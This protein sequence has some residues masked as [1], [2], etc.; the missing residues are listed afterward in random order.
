M[1]LYDIVLTNRYLQ[2]GSK[3]QVPC[4]YVTSLDTLADE[5]KCKTDTYI[6][7]FRLAFIVSIQSF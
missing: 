6:D 1:M 2:T 4:V 7:W 3:P 5:Y